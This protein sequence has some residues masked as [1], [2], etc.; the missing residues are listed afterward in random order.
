MQLYKGDLSAKDAW[1][2]LKTRSG[3]QLVDVRTTAEWHY[4]GI[5]DLRPIDKVAL[6]AQWRL[7]NDMQINAHFMEQL[8]QQ[9]LNTS[10]QNGDILIMMCRTGGRSMEAAQYLTSLGFENCYNLA[11]GFEG[12][13]DSSGH[14]G[15]VAGWKAANLSWRQD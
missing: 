8:T 5:P 11:D 10:Y 3:S 14:R 15:L 12:P 7:L 2:M 9:L 13:L 6:T 4:V 1:D